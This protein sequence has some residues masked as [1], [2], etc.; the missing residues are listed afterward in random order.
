MKGLPSQNG[1]K[2]STLF[3]TQQ[4]VKGLKCEVSITGWKPQEILVIQ[5]WFGTRATYV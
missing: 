4:R 5:Q 2:K 1:Y 3:I